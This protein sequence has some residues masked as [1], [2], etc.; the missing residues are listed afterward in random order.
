MRAGTRGSLHVPSLLS[1]PVAGP[2]LWPLGHTDLS[3]IATHVWPENL[4]APGAVKL[5]DMP[6]AWPE[7]VALLTAVTIAALCIIVWVTALSSAGTVIYSRLNN[8][9]AA[10][11]A[12]A[13]F[14]TVLPLWLVLRIVDSVKGGPGRR[15]EALRNR[16]VERSIARRIE[17][18]IERPIGWRAES[19][20]EPRFE[21]DAALMPGE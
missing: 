12:L 2:G 3:G 11:A 19:R 18:R 1:G 16:P 9:L 15:L 10:W 8:A 5:R 17:P 4:R 6:L 7:K 14:G 21:M 13:E 20:I